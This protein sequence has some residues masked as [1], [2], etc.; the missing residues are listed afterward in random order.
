MKDLK[1]KTVMLLLRGLAHLPFFALYFL[2]DII[3]FFVAH[4]IRYRRKVIMVNLRNSFPSKSEKE[5][6]TIMHG[7]Y[8]HMCDLIVETIKLLHISDRQLTEHI[9]VCDAGLIEQLAAD[10]SPIV[11]FLGHYGN[12]EW[13]QEV[14]RHY[15]CPLYNAEIYRHLRSSV[16][17]RM[18]H[19]IRSRFNTE[20][21]E[22]AHAVRRL[23]QLKREGTQFLVGFI[24]DQRPN[25]ANL[26]H[27]TRFLNQDTAYAAGGEEIGRHVGAK[28]VYLDI[29]KPRRGHYRM[30][31]KAI[32]P[33]DADAKYPYTLAFMAMLE[34][35]INRTP[36]FW[37]W[38][39]NR[40]KFKRENNKG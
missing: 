13:V 36:Q 17:D 25:S 38:S 35:T 26:N 3:R 23:L 11:V 32:T 21:I 15:S 18:Y 14:T 33:T 37:L 1:F 16:S 28:Y 27:W 40:W 34:A 12:W 4:V 39:H 24:S 30:T 7:Y 8:R 9:Q 6:S 22:Q 19:V 29:E 20:Q 5:L 2:S 31:F 10:G